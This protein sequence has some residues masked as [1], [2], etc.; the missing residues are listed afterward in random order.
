[1]E[2]EQEQTNV[3][4]HNK[5][6]LEKLQSVVRDSYQSAAFLSTLDALGLLSRDYVGKPGVWEFTAV[7]ACR[8]LLIKLV[9]QTRAPEES[10]PEGRSSSPR[11]RRNYLSP[12]RIVK[13]LPRR[14][15]EVRS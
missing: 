14:Y 8:E 7:S 10:Q 2:E 12:L 5:D 15:G 11:I 4:A 6:A 13:V 3:D 9:E 1:L